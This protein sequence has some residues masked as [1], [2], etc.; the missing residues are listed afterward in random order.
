MKAM[1]LSVAVGAA[2]LGGVLFLAG[3][4]GAGRGVAASGASE[5][6]A[7]GGAVTTSTTYEV[8]GMTCTGCEAAIKAGVKKLPGVGKVDASY[9]DGEAVVA[10]DPEKVSDQD[11]TKAIEKLGYTVTDEIPGVSGGA[12][13]GQGAK[14]EQ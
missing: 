14:E 8:S 11:I 12:E 4:G 2:L 13:K 6:G 3:C 9:K 10:Y 5:A 1:T 7:S